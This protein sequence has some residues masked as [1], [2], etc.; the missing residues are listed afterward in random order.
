MKQKMLLR[1]LRS[2]FL[3]GLGSGITWN[4]NVNS[5]NNMTLGTTAGTGLT[6]AAP[7]PPLSQSVALSTNASCH[8]DGSDS[9]KPPF[10]PLKMMRAIHVENFGGPEVLQ[11]KFNL[12]VPPLTK[13]QVLVRVK[14]AGVNPV[15]TYVREGQYSR[16]PDLPYIP[17]ADASGVIE[18]VGSDVQNLKVGQRVFVTG[19]N[20][21]SYAEYIV[22]EAIYVFPLHHRL[23]FAQGAAL[24]VPYFTAYKALIMGAK[25]KPGETVLIHGASGAVGTAAVQIARSMGVI[26]FGTAGTKDGMDVVAKCG[27][28]HVFNH[29][30]KSYE[31][32]MLELLGGEGFDVIIEHLANINLGHH[33]QMLK[34]DARIMVVGCRGSVNIN[35]R[36]LMLP[37]A[38]IRGVTLQGNTTVAQYKEIGS[39][40]VAG[41]EAGWVNPVINKEYAM[42]EAQQVHYDIIHSKGAKGKLVLKVGQDIASAS[43]MFETCTLDSNINGV[44]SNYLV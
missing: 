9:R 29:N 15:E 10:E 16:L 14:C 7:P 1:N 30:H 38:S 33:V 8:I 2:R 21:G 44:D 11:L 12:I 25:A 28:H 36:H 40:I 35:P 27:A 43:M 42:E 31:K 3:S 20:S 19:R 24:G 22:T 18:K 26:V 4:L 37:E 41:I 34:R 23:T 13:T 32:K 17:G 39:A 6:Y 5:G